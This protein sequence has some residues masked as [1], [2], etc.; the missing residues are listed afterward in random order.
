ME[1]PKHKPACCCPAPF[2]GAHVAIM[3]T[4]FAIDFL[5]G[6]VQA[7]F[8][9]STR[10]YIPFKKFTAAITCYAVRARARALL[11]RVCH[12]AGH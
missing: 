5:S 6:H 7:R 11:Q 8:L 4:C 12:L 9:P 10:S 1:R 3:L 2:R